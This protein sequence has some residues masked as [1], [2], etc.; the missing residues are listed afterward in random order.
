MFSYI[1]KNSKKHN[2]K[3]FKLSIVSDK[4]DIKKSIANYLARALY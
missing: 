1:W 3:D 2:S 4:T